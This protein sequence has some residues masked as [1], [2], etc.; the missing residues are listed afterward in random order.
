MTT[1]LLLGL[2]GGVGGAAGLFFFSLSANLKLLAA[3]LDRIEATLGKTV[4][5]VAVLE[6]TAGG[7]VSV[8]VV[9]I[10]PAADRPAT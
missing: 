1:D 10:L 2:L 8:P 6:S 5:R 9:R 7:G 4:E 3:S